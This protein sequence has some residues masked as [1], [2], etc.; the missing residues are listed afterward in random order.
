MTGKLSCYILTYNSEK[1]IEDVILAA[2]KVAD[3]IIVVDSGSNDSTEAITIRHH[4]RFYYNKMED[5]VKQRN[6][7]HKKCSHDWILCLDSDEIPDTKLLNAIKNLKEHNFRES[8]NFDCYRLK[9]EWY[10][11]GKKVGSMYPAI[12]PDYVIRLY[13]KSKASF[14]GST[15]VHESLGGFEKTG[16]INEGVLRH[17]TFETTDEI[18]R[19]LHHYTS[20]A[21]DDALQ[22]NKKSSYPRAIAHAVCAFCKFYI[23]KGGFRDGKVG[24]LAGVY[25]FRYVFCKYSKLKKLKRLSIQKERLQITL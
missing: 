5:F 13:K 15:K 21:A 20:L 3:E 4:A 1:Y 10:V 19:K 23:I 12:S 6:Y 8:E 14:H 9:R 2:K 18:E 16:G 11:L 22:K 17:F 25:A 7:A 24:F